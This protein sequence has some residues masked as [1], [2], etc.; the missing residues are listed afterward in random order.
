MMVISNTYNHSTI[1]DHIQ[2]E[3]RI[4]YKFYCRQAKTA[5]TSPAK[6]VKPLKLICLAPEQ[7]PPEIK[8]IKLK[9]GS[10]E[11]AFYNTMTMALLAV[12]LTGC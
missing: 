3:V 5:R 2:S 9:K 10:D 7:V 11:L 12:S 6:I 4:H 8:E 1:F